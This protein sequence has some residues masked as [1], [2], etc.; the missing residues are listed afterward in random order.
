M[1]YINANNHDVNDHEAV[2]GPAAGLE[3]SAQRLQHAG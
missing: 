3:G 2:P 1:Y